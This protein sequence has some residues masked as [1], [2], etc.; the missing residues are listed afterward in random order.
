MVYSEIVHIGNEISSK[1]VKFQNQMLLYICGIWSLI[2]PYSLVHLG[3]YSSESVSE[4]ISGNEALV[5]N[6][7]L[8]QYN[9]L[10]TIHPN[11]YISLEFPYFSINSFLVRSKKNW[12]LKKIIWRYRLCIGY[13]LD[14]LEKRISVTELKQEA[15]YS[16]V[17]NLDSLNKCWSSKK[18]HNELFLS[19]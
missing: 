13:I 5:S 3:D 4:I 6:K 12:L 11:S 10:N 8:F 2:A 17:Y 18:T 16:T 9:D 7:P 1:K 19:P 15:R 14:L